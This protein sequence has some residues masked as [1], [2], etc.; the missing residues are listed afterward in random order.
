VVF[1]E[2]IVD[3]KDQQAAVPFC[4]DAA[5]SSRQSEF[6]ATAYPP[7]GVQTNVVLADADAPAEEF[8]ALTKAIPTIAP[9]LPVDLPGGS[10]RVI[11]LPKDGSSTPSIAIPARLSPLAQR[12]RA[13][14]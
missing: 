2:E 8:A 7:A 5:W 1:G 12:A 11:G 13:S 3:D 14:V 6:I 10:G 9:L 4:R